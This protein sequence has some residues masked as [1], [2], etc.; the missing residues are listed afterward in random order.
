[1]LKVRIEKSTPIK[2]QEKKTFRKDELIKEGNSMQKKLII[3][4][5][6]Y[7]CRCIKFC[8]TAF[9]SGVGARSATVLF[10]ELLRGVL[11]RGN[12]G[13]GPQPPGA[14][15]STPGGVEL[16][17]SLNSVAVII[18]LHFIIEHYLNKN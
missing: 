18:K 7:I 11:E 4:K 9:N 16:T 10:R 2:K 6:T 13:N 5:A 17:R 3:K 1:M 15:L 14:G 8:Q 12:S